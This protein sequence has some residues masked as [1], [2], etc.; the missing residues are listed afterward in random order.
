MNNEMYIIFILFMKNEHQLENFHIKR[1]NNQPENWN[2]ALKREK[3]KEDTTE[4]K[5]LSNNEVIMNL[6]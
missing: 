3:R 2:S 1:H 5:N 6:N 4:K